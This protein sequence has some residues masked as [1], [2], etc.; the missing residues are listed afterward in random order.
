MWR[1]AVANNCEENGYWLQ[2]QHAGRAETTDLKQLTRLWRAEAM[3]W[4]AN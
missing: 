3:P 2:P 1:A 4:D